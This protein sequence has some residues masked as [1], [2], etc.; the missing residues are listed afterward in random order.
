MKTRGGAGRSKYNLHVN[1]I[2]DMQLP[3]PFDGGA[4]VPPDPLDALALRD[5]PATVG[6]DSWI[7]RIF[8]IDASGEFHGDVVIA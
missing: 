7:L 4:F 5:L 1:L 8:A 6:A 2:C 3:S